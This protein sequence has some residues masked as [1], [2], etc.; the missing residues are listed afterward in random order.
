MRASKGHR[1]RLQ[2]KIKIERNT[3]RR[4]RREWLGEG[5]LAIGVASHKRK[6]THDC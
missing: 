2:K 1:R 5:R 4:N 3:A 6:E